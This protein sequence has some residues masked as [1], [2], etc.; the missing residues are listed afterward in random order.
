MI[1]PKLS[2]SKKV[3]NLHLSTWTRTCV[4]YVS[5]PTLNRQELNLKS[6][7]NPW[8]Q[9]VEDE[10]HYFR[11]NTQKQTNFQ[12]NC[13]LIDQVNLRARNFNFLR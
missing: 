6:W 7:K 3:Q 10:I 8:K 1:I 9:Q 4:P 13:N 5:F 12:S 11:V 2:F